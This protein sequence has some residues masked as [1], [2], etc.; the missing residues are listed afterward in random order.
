M[1]FYKEIMQQSIVRKLSRAIVLCMLFDR[2]ALRAEA[3]SLASAVSKAADL[4]HC[5]TPDCL[6]L[7]SVLSL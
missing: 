1:R 3:R 7:V 6:L 5:P 4:R 2:I